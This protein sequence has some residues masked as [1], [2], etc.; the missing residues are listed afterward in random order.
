MKWFLT[1]AV[2]AAPSAVWAACEHAAGAACPH[3]GACG[4]LG[5]ALLAGVAALGYWVLRSAEKDAGAVRW[6]GRVAGWVLLVVGLAGFVCG[7]VCHAKKNAHG[8]CS[9]SGVADYSQG[10]GYSPGGYGAGGTMEMP[11]GHP[12]ID[13]MGK[14]RSKTP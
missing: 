1:M 14:K 11:P 10:G 5:G 8:K 7:A 9:T 4:G 2:L 12:P 6:A 3:G 13:G